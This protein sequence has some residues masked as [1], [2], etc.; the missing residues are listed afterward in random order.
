MDEWEQK[1]WGEMTPMERLQ[2]VAEARQNPCIDDQHIYEDRVDAVG[3][4][5]FLSQ[6]CT[7]CFNMQGWIYGWDTRE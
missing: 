7:R 2:L 1:S 5:T 4:S 3:N 6:V